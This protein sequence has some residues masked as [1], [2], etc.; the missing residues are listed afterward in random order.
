MQR[1]SIAFCFNDRF[2]PLAAGAIASL[3]KHAGNDCKYDIYVI[4]DDITDDHLFMLRQINNKENIR[5]QH[6]LFN[7]DSIVAEAIHTTAAFSKDVYTR[8]FLHRI[9]PNLDRILYL[10]VD[11]IITSDVAVLYNTNIG[12]YPIAAVGG[13]KMTIEEKIELLKRPSWIKKWTVNGHYENMYEYQTKYLGLKDKELLTYFNSGV[14]IFDLKKAGKIIEAGFRSLINKKFATPDQDMLN[15][16]FKGNAYMLDKRY[17]MLSDSVCNYMKENGVLP[18]IIHYAGPRKPNSHGIKNL[19]GAEY[20][21]VLQETDFLYPALEELMDCKVAKAKNEVIKSTNK[22]IADTV[23]IEDLYNKIKRLEKTKR[24]Q[25]LIRVVIKLLV[26]KK[27]Y[28]K[29]KRYP[30]QFFEDSKSTFI[31]F[32]GKYYN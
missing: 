31:R 29:L 19:G 25:K 6:I 26:N 9:L 20:W 10:D 5:I 8:I 23:K 4:S 11:I 32:L 24:R 2:C 7:L 16:L 13:G 3:V 18:D 15:I 14:M 27:K 28:K 22:K 21:K 12:G 30:I 1:I 17:N